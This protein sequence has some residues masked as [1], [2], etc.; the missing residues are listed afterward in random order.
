MPG[1]EDVDASEFG[2]AAIFAEASTSPWREVM[3][4]RTGGA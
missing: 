2:L 3:V 4:R 1:V